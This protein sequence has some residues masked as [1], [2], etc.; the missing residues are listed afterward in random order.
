[1]V[2]GQPLKAGSQAGAGRFG[3][4]ADL[5]QGPQ[6]VASRGFCPLLPP[7]IVA[8]KVAA[9]NP[10]VGSKGQ[11][12]AAGGTGKNSF[13]SGFPES[14][15]R[16]LSGPPEMIEEMV[17]H[18]VHL[19]VQFAERGPA[20]GLENGQVEVDVR[21]VQAQ[22]QPDGF[23]K[24]GNRFGRKNAVDPEPN[25]GFVPQG[26][27]PGKHQAAGAWLP[28]KIL[29]RSVITQGDRESIP[30]QIAKDRI[31]DQAAVGGEGIMRLLAERR[32]GGLGQ[33]HYLLKKAEGEER[34]TAREIEIV[35][36]G[37]KR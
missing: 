27:E 28:L 2:H 5:G 24:V 19:V 4:P 20:P 32:A 21:D 35:V 13:W 23:R 15:E 25:P 30:A 3:T 10:S 26:F 18:P 11:P 36:P 16:H 1:M 22:Q 31:G 9:P 34:L 37:Q 29:G 14:F 7:K 33:S 12:V 17:D 6:A 8:E